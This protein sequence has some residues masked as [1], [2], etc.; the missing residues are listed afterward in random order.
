MGVM[1][2]DLEIQTIVFKK[3]VKIVKNWKFGKTGKQLRNKV[4]L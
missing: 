1:M 2:Y 4:K 3:Q